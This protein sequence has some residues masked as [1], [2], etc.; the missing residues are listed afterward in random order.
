MCF[1]K[2]QQAPSPEAGSS[3]RT[4]LPAGAP[5]ASLVPTSPCS[6]SPPWGP[7]SSTTCS[8]P[9]PLW[10]DPVAA[11]NSR[12]CL[13]HPADTH[14]H[15]W[16][17]QLLW[18]HPSVHLGLSP[19]L[20]PSRPS[21]SL[22]PVSAGPDERHRERL[23]RTRKGP[24]T[25]CHALPSPVLAAASPRLGSRVRQAPGETRNGSV[26][27][28]TRASQSALDEGLPRELEP[29]GDSRALLGPKENLGWH[30]GG[31]WLPCTNLLSI[32]TC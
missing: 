2:C 13:P 11:G 30:L 22:V 7:S 8:T 5:R 27:P 26:Q 16:S 3:L 29:L 28:V 19:S 32:N 4:F 25:P 20:H 15:L 23:P 21:S 10:T 12:V 9:C 14:T 6:A 17:H 24:E 1:L 18:P 31:T